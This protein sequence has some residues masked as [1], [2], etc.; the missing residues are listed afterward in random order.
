MAVLALN[1]AASVP[2]GSSSFGPFNLPTVP[3]DQLLVTLSLATWPAVRGGTISVRLRL[4]RTRKG[5]YVT[6]WEDTFA[7]QALTRGGVPQATASFGIGLSEPVPA[8]SRLMVD[9]DTDAAFTTA[10]T[11]EAA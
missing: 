5:A 11:V 1:V 3:S 9:V 10:V 2:A 4:D 6:E 7:Y 8:R